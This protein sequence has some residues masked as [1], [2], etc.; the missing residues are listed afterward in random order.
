[1]P[2]PP[3]TASSV[4][5]RPH[6]S[7]R[8]A[9][10]ATRPFQP[11]QVIHVFQ[12]PLILH[13]TA[14]HLDSV[15]TYCLRPG[16]PRACSRCHAAF[17][18]N[19]ACQRAGWTAIHRNECKALQ[20]RTGSKTGADLPTPVRILLQALL[21]QGVERGLADLEGHAERRSNAKAWADLEMMATA[22][23]AFAGR[24]GDTARA[25][26]LLCKIQTNAFHRLDEDLA[27]QVGIFLEP[28]LA[29]AN[30]SCI[31]NATVLFMGRKAVL[32]AE[33]AIQAGQ[34][35]EISYTG[36]CVA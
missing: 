26:E 28:T 13:P 3:G 16:S 15:C 24:G 20:R 9:L 5:V 30:H 14:D 11:G 17:Y 22:A 23:C 6:P 25:I 12:Q 29:M 36:W 35:I 33:T 34:E 2:T 4:D 21:E 8:R 32:R 31:P 19:A 10:H 1:M 18:C 7:K 27:G